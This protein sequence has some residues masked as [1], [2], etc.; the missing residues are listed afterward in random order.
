MLCKNV[1]CQAF[2]KRKDTFNCQCE[3]SFD[4]STCEKRKMF[5]R[6]MRLDCQK[7]KGAVQ[8]ER[9]RHE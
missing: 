7:I 9:D 4:R 6:V 3:F 2:E 5:N 8:N 1:F